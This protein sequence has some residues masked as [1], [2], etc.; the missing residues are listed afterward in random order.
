MKKRLI[1]LGAEI[2]FFGKEKR[3]EKAKVRCMKCLN[4]FQMGKFTDFKNDEIN[5]NYEF[6]YCPHCGNKLLESESE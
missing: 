3:L 2:I 4:I 5:I 6:T 1:E